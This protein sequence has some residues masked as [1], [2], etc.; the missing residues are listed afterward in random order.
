[1]SSEKLDKVVDEIIGETF[2]Y[3]INIMQRVQQP[4]D[5]RRDPHPMSGI[6]HLEESRCTRKV[7]S[8]VL[9]EDEFRKL[10]NAALAQF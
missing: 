8:T 7:L 6:G 4:P 10:K 2:E 5:R 9:T 3:E 1:M